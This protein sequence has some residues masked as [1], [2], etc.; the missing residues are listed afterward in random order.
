MVAL[1]KSND[2]VSS[3]YPLCTSEALIQSGVPMTSLTFLSSEWLRTARVS[4]AF[5]Q[6]IALR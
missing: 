5:A 1:L 4:I 2:C 6:P 3:R